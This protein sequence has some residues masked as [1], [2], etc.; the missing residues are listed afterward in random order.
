MVQKYGHRTVDNFLSPFRKR[1][2][3]ED[4]L[5]F[6]SKG[7]TEALKAYGN[8]IVPQVMYEIFRAIEEVEHPQKPIIRMIDLIHTDD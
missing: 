7:R 3:I 4:R 5:P 6:L 1:A 2:S 8:A